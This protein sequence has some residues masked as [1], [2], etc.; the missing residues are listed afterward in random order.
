MA[1]RVAGKHGLAVK[2]LLSQRRASPAGLPQLTQRRSTVG[3]FYTYL[4]SG[5]FGASR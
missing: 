3:L 2:Y 5:G 1:V 4:G